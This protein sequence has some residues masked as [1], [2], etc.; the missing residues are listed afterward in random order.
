[1]NVWKLPHSRGVH[2]S[3]GVG[4]RAQTL[5]VS[6]PALQL[7]GVLFGGGNVLLKQCTAEVAHFSL[8][9]WTEPAALKHQSSPEGE[10]GLP[11]EFFHRNKRGISLPSL[12]FPPSVLLS[13]L[14]AVLAAAGAQL[15]GRRLLLRARQP[16]RGASRRP[17]VPQRV[18][19]RHRA[20]DGHE[21]QREVPLAL[22][23]GGPAHGEAPADGDHA[24]L[25]QV[26]QVD[27]WWCSNQERDNSMKK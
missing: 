10:R 4:S 2:T 16:E 9:W 8:Q 1:M 6:C 21:V 11:V 25:Q 15:R 26:R 14:Q 3:V 18:L 27:P 13:V 12:T 5:F 24:Q 22:F 19:R 7:E 17:A 20:R 23:P